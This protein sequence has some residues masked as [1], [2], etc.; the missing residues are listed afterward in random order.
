VVLDGVRNPF[1]VAFPLVSFGLR[2]PGREITVVPMVDP[3]IDELDV[4]LELVDVFPKLVLPK[5][6]LPVVVEVVGIPK[7]PVVAPPPVP[8]CCALAT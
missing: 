5:P 6:V 8:P 1:L 7:E 4:E 3:D 2:K